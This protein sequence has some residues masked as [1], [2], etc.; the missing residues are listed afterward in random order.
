MLEGLRARPS[1]QNKQLCPRLLLYIDEILVE[2]DL[3]V[4]SQ[5]VSE[6]FCDVTLIFA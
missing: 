3:Q 2:L 1:Y 4:S 6:A 5:L